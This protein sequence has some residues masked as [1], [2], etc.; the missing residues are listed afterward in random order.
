MGPQ[1][2]EPLR[3][4]P[5]EPFSLDGS[6]PGFCLF[7]RANTGRGALCLLACPALARLEPVERSRAGRR[8]TASF[9]L[10]SFLLRA[11]IRRKGCS[12]GQCDTV[13]GTQH[14]P[15]SS[16]RHLGPR[17]AGPGPRGVT[18]K[19]GEEAVDQAAD[20]HVPSIVGAAEA[21]GEEPG[22]S[23]VLCNTGHAVRPLRPRGPQGH[24]MPTARPRW[25]PG[26]VR[27]SDRPSVAQPRPGS[28]PVRGPGHGPWMPAT[29]TQGRHSY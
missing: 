13:V 23:W 8:S 12:G 22:A 29:A 20:D 1:A 5:L 16:R 14:R 9:L 19:R 10:S 26:A 6:P 18:W 4:T 15:V 28:G 2:D 17:R 25:A 24:T 21:Q 3:E 27:V 7:Q 11:R